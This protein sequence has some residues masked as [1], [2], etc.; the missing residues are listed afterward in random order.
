[1]PAPL[2]RSFGR[3]DASRCL[4]RLRGTRITYACD[5]T[6]PEV[7]LR[8]LTEEWF[9]H[10]KATVGVGPGWL[11]RVLTV[12]RRPGTSIVGLALTILAP[13]DPDDDSDA[14]YYA[15]DDVEHAVGPLQSLVEIIPRLAPPQL[16]PAPQQ[17]APPLAAPS[18]PASERQW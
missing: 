8:N 18:A 11:S 4:P 17:A 2:W 9:S 5:E 14:E 15:H 13:L 6:F 12:A 10:L 3:L 1:M 7:Q 16:A